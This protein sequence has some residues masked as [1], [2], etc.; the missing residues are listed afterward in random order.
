M[1]FLNFAAGLI[2]AAA[3]PAA[4]QTH[5]SS[6][7]RMPHDS[8]AHGAM[9]SASHAALHAQ[10]HGEWTGTMGAVHGDT[11]AFHVSLADSAYHAGHM[12]AHDA[13]RGDTVQWT[14][15]LDGKPCKAIGALK[16]GAAGMADSLTGRISCPDGDLTFSLRKTTP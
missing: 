8:S 3:L 6:H 16:R 11:Q 14:Q 12:A 2:A 9:D 7:P 4:A 15:D 13:M 1:R 10:I 5:P